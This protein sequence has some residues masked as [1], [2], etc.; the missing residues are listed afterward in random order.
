[1]SEKV[2]QASEVI[3]PF[4]TIRDGV[5]WVNAAGRIAWVG[6]ASALPEEAKILAWEEYPGK[7]LLPGLIDIHV[8]GGFGISFGEGDLAGGLHTYA[9]KIAFSGLAGFLLSVS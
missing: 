4:E 6:K 9:E 7:R 2:L 1:M 8:H 5:V 3:T